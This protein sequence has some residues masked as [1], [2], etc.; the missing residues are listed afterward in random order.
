MKLTTEE[1]NASPLLLCSRP[2][3]SRSRHACEMRRIGRSLM[4]T[5][6][7]APNLGAGW[8][9][10]LLRSAEKKGWSLLVPTAVSLLSASSTCS[11]HLRSNDILERN[12]ILMNYIMLGAGRRRRPPL[13]SSIWITRKTDG[14]RPSSILF[15]CYWFLEPGAPR[16]NKSRRT[17]H[18]TDVDING[19]NSIFP[20]GT[21]FSIRFATALINSLPLFQT[22]SIGD[23]LPPWIFHHDDAKE[24]WI[25]QAYP[26]NDNQ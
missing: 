22:R 26:I 10:V 19:K 21:I 12:P 6:D 17:S 18:M 8:C 9:M 7:C 24:Y 3:R 16:S 13:L 5:T 15:G 4:S 14:H 25:P 11:V 23:R 2:N 1:A 20:L